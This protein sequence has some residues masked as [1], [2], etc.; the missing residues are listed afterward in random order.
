MQPLPQGQQIAHVIEGI[1]KLIPRQRPGAP[2]HQ[3]FALAEPV[4][5]QLADQGAMADRVNHADESRGDLQVEQIAWHAPDRAMAQPDLF[6]AR[7]NDGE[8]GRVRQQF[9]Q[10]PQ[11]LLGKR[12]GIDEIERFMRRE[13][14]QAQLGM[15]RILTDELGVKPHLAGAREVG[16][17]RRQFGGVGDHDF[18]GMVHAVRPCCRLAATRSGALRVA[19]R[20]NGT[21]H[22]A[23]R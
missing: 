14:D 9:P 17:A 20:L 11:L 19:S 3:R 16:A 12:E 4:L 5:Q 10:G 13:L 18:G 23:P 8:P 6:A 2:F 7:V 1:A 15:I 21:T 22:I